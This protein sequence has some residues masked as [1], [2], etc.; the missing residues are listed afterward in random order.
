MES[1]NTLGVETP[2]GLTAPLQVLRDF[3]VFMILIKIPKPS[4]VPEI[5]TNFE[6]VGFHSA[7]K[8]LGN[9]M[10][11]FEMETQFS[12]FRKDILPYKLAYHLNFQNRNGSR[13]VEWGEWGVKLHRI[14]LTKNFFSQTRHPPSPKKLL[15]LHIIEVFA[16]FPLDHHE[17]QK[18]ISMAAHLHHRYLKQLLGRTKNSF[19]TIGDTMYHKFREH[20]NY[21]KRQKFLWGMQIPGL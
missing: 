20:F 8:L 14:C 6:I 19:A 1:A 3:A 15:P 10:C 17:G 11:Y 2:T 16:E 5:L 13:K 12:T 4:K 7:N 21:V 9:G 18:T